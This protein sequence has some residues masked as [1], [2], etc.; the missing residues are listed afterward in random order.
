MKA[1]IIKIGYIRH[2]HFFKVITNNTIYICV[3]FLLKEDTNMPKNWFQ[4]LIFTFIMVIVM[5]YAMICYN[6]A[7]EFGALTNEV[8]LIA[9]NELWFMG[10]IA[11]GLD[12]FLVGFLTKKISFKLIKENYRNSFTLTLS[13]SI[14]SVCFMCPLMSF[15]ATLIIKQPSLADFFATWVQTSILNFPMALLWQLVVAGPLVRFIFRLI[16]IR[17]NKKVKIEENKE[18][19]KKEL[20]N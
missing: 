19:N 1:D 18:E 10:L 15:F 3:V 9:F 11:F 8:F 20:E 5:V 2:A 13:I 16:F 12:F 4:E 14:L 6:I 7:I 17:K